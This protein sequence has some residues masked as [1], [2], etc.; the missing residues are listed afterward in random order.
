M[1]LLLLSLKKS[2]PRT[3]LLS[4]RRDAVDVEK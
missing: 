4:A 2:A 3:N 1:T